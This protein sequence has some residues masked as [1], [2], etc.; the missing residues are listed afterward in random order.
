[1][2]MCRVDRYDIEMK[3][4]KNINCFEISRKVTFIVCHITCV[5][6]GHILN[7]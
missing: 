1:M 7:F 5:V 2:Y 4:D 3:E 6:S